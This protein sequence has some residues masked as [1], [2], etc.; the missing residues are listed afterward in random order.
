MTKTP[1]ARQRNL[2]PEA[3]KKLNQGDMDEKNPFSGVHSRTMVIMGYVELSRFRGV[4][5]R[6]FGRFVLDGNA[7]RPPFN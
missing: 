1:Q 7:A 5:S 6:F 4:E 3:V 2:P